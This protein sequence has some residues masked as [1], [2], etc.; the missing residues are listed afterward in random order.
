MK[1][2]RKLLRIIGLFVLPL[3]VVPLWFHS[4]PQPW[5]RPSDAYAPYLGT[6]I[7]GGMWV[8]LLYFTFKRGPIP[9]ESLWDEEMGLGR[10]VPT[11]IQMHLASRNPRHTLKRRA[12]GS[13]DTDAVPGIIEFDPKIRVTITRLMK[14]Q[15]PND[16]SVLSALTPDEIISRLCDI[17]TQATGKNTYTAVCKAW[18]AEHKLL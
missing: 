5:E 2:L 8:G 7:I 1:L 6:I 13:I 14:Q 3:M 16:P 17:Y 10:L 9:I 15:L 12:D 11:Y 18:C 4:A